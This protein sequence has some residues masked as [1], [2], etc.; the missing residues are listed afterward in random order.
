MSCVCIDHLAR[1]EPDP[2]MF[3]CAF[4]LCNNSSCLVCSFH[5]ILIIPGGTEDCVNNEIRLVDGWVERVGV[6]E[7]CYNGVWGAIC[8]DSEVPE[9]YDSFGFYWRIDSQAAVICR[10]L[11]LLEP[12]TSQ[13]FYSL[14]R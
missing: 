1:L 11:G 7:V 13:L 6:V 8:D 2:I 10:Q 9:E 5:N 12:N 3:Q 14:R 4:A